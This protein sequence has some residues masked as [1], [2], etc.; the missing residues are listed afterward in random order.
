MAGVLIGLLAV[1]Y[2]VVL[3]IIGV[4]AYK[5]YRPDR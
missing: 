2:G 1:F 4:K 5:E 3:S